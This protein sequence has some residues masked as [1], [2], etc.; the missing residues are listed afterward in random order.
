M[1]KIIALMLT[2]AVLT[3]GGTGL[4]S[5]EPA[6]AADTGKSFEMLKGLGI[7]PTD[8]SETGEMNRGEFAR[9]LAS[10][11]IDSEAD[12]GITY[13]SDMDA[14]ADAETSRA[15]NLLANYGILKGN[16]VAVYHAENALAFEEAVTALVRVLGYEYVAEENGGYP[17]GYLSTA[18]KIGL[19]KGIS[20]NEALNTAVA[21]LLE[22]ALDIK[23]L[24]RSDWGDTLKMQVDE[25]T[26]MESLLNIKTD[27]G[28]VYAVGDMALESTHAVG[29]QY[30]LV[31]SRLLRMEDSK[32]SMAQALLGRMVKVYYRSESDE[33]VLCYLMDTR[34]SRVLT[35]DL[36]SEPVVENGS[37]TYEGENGRMRTVSTAPAPYVVY[38]GRPISK[39]PQFG[40]IG[41]LTCI[42]SSGGR[43]DIL[44]IEDYK[45]YVVEGVAD[46]GAVIAAKYAQD[47][48]PN[49]NEVEELYLRDQDGKDIKMSDIKENDVLSV[50]ASADEENSY[51]MIRRSRKRF[52]GKLEEY[53]GNNVT[54][55]RLKLSAVEYSVTPE[56][57]NYLSGRDMSTMLNLADY[58]HTDVFGNVAHID[59]VIGT[60]QNILGYLTA[61]SDNVDAFSTP[62]IKVFSQNNR[63][64]V[65]TLSGRM[66]FN[67]EKKIDGRAAYE[68]FVDNVS[69][70]QLISY[71][72]D[73]KGEVTRI[74]TATNYQRE[75][76]HKVADVSSRYRSGQK[77]FKSKFI[78]RDDTVV[79]ILPDG[80]SA[81][82][83]S[84]YR[85]GTP[86]DFRDGTTYT[87]SAYTQSED[88]YT[89]D[90]VIYRENFNSS[91]ETARVAV[92]EDVIWALN[93]KGEHA[94][95]LK[96]WSA[97]GVNI[98]MP[99]REGTARQELHRGDIIQ[100]TR[101]INN[102]IVSY[103]II[104]SCDTDT[105]YPAENP[106]TI[107]NVD[108]DL[109][110][111]MATPVGLDGTILK[112]RYPGNSEE[113]FNLAGVKVLTVR[114]TGR[115][116]VIEE[117]AIADLMRGADKVFVNA[118][119]NSPSVVYAYMR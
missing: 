44:I 51:M 106:Y 64:E 6:A 78:M 54:N 100:Y 39:I 81:G 58:F 82:D 99:V 16:P 84:F 103:T 77:T 25:E 71:R 70:N 23:V 63:F 101:N 60:N 43:Y 17:N 102:E 83:E 21:M 61:I 93:N 69:P 91:R 86:S 85:I 22:N 52:L 24:N 1:R 98:E 40:T 37:I 92:V 10:L 33:D 104:Y 66:S 108:D 47:V 4:L 53:S 112:V 94:E 30:V 46:N 19:T 115:G 14:A 75:G 107:N 89:V 65:L 32:R 12:T 62:K 67:G 114:R 13:F 41:T 76:L 97:Y 7:L 113:Y 8:F 111:G 80:S 11:Y 73:S 88:S 2:V 116:V 5:V 90:A 72:T 74:D 50:A 42:A 28:I 117:G 18:A 118:P 48:L 29:E 110:Y 57:Y 26:L 119:Y 87:V 56:F 38:N 20:G 15:V 35:V 31:G 59:G 109:R 55:Y 95:L 9:I 79:F 96:L 68:W 49:L 36:N 34:K 3:M 45:T 27:S 105:W